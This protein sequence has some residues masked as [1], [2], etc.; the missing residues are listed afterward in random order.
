MR[1]LLVWLK[2]I[3]D[4]GRQEK[5]LN[6]LVVGFRSFHAQPSP[7]RRGTELKLRNPSTARSVLTFDWRVEAAPKKLQDYVQGQGQKH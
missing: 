7:T 1:F 6:S 2:L 3:A 4:H 5:D